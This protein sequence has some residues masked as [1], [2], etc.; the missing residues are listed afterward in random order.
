MQL[1]T[2]PVASGTFTICDRLGWSS[3]ELV[4][5]SVLNTIYV[6]FERIFHVRDCVLN[7]QQFHQNTFAIRA[8]RGFE[9]GT[10]ILN[11]IRHVRTSELGTLPEIVWIFCRANVSKGENNGQRRFGVTYT[12][13][14]NVLP[15]WGVIQSA[16]FHGTRG[17]YRQKVPLTSFRIQFNELQLRVHSLGGTVYG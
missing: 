8:V 1:L 4:F 14:S 13:R 16:K 11:L 7:P 10:N 2:L 15:I 9:L 17:A 6:L 3:T 12:V 5:C